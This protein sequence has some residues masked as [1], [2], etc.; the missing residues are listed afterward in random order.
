M[1]FY[2]RYVNGLKE[3]E[4]VTEEIDPAMFGTMLHTAMR[5]L[6][7]GF[8]GK[9]LNP[10]NMDAILNN[11]QTISDHI[12]I[13]IIEKFR[14]E[15]DILVAIN[16]M[17]VREVLFKYIIRILELDQKA[18][19]FTI[20]AVEKPVSFKL[21]F[22]TEDGEHE[23]LAGGIIDRVDIKDG[24]ARIVDYKTGKIADAIASIEDL[25]E[26]DRS[27]EFDGWLQTL[28][29]CEG[30]L[31][32]KPEIKVRPSVYKLNK[33]P[34]KNDSDKLRIKESQAGEILLEDY[35][36]VRQE[37]MENLDAVA[38]KIFSNRE[39]FIMTSDIRNKCSYCPYRILCMR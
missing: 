13:A 15:S 19:P 23:L 6:Y 32:N 18:A 9:M 33:A 35:N 16:E 17:M 8:V 26:D 31:V 30:Y 12:N 25:F 21:T 3:P 37:F 24:I 36:T 1:K 2:Y 39:P 27:R 38:R 7:S 4:K 10:D 34:E 20:L 14:K 28:L 5:N 29:Y 22:K 11:E